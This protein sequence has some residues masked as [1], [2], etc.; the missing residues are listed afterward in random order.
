MDPSMGLATRSSLAIS[1]RDSTDEESHSNI[2]QD[3]ER[4]Q[5]IELQ[6][7][8]TTFSE[9]LGYIPKVDTGNVSKVV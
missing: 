8:M 4:K 5:T 7:M 9:S 6:K 3:L 1:L 2:S